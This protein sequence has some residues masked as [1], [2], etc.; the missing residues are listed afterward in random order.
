VSF[1]LI[2]QARLPVLSGRI[3][4]GLKLEFPHSFS[5][6]VTHGCVL[7]GHRVQ[8]QRELV[9]GCIHCHGD[10]S[11]EVWVVVSVAIPIESPYALHSLPCVLANPD[12]FVT[13][14]DGVTRASTGDGHSLEGLHQA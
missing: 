5:C 4:Y 8:L 6:T 13:A 12:P 10:S 11:L 2:L 14:A 1:E 3:V 7:C 9:L